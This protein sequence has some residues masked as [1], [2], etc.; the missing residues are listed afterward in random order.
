MRRRRRR[1]DRA[2]LAGAARRAA[3]TPRASLRPEGDQA[4]AIE[5]LAERVGGITDP[6]AAVV[7]ELDAARSPTATRRSP[8][9][10]TSSPGSASRARRLRELVRADGPAARPDF[11]VMV[12]VDDA[13]AA[14]RLRPDAD[15]AEPDAGRG[16]ELRG[17]RLLRSTGG[18]A[19][20][21]RRR[22]RARLRHRDGVQGR[23]RRR[24]T[25]SRWPRATST[26]TRLDALPDDP[27]ARSSSSRRRRSRRRSRQGD[28]DP[29]T[30]QVLEPLLGG[31]LSR[32]DRG[33][34]DRDRRHG[35]LRPRGDA[36]LRR[37][38]LATESS[39]LAEPAGRVL[40]RGRGARPRPE[41]RAR[42][43]TSSPAAAC[44]GRAR[45]S[46][47]C[48]RAT[49][50]D[51]GEDV[52]GWLGDAAA[53]VEGTAAPGFSAGLIAQTSDPEAPRRCSRCCEG[54]PSGTPACAPAARRR[55]P[56]YG[57]SLG[58]PGI[59]GGA[60]AGVIGDQLVA[61]VG[62]TVDQALEP[63]RDARRQPR[64]PGRGRGA[65]R[66]SARRRCSSTCRSSSRS[67]SS[68][69]RRRRR[70]RG[71]PPVPR[72]LLAR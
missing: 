8:T 6:G 49:G 31:P 54:S 63:E 11:A 62:A 50:L 26:P 41:P 45:S 48:M 55:A 24:A 34:P 30:A 14:S 65:R 53:F 12:E 52:F 21:V 47:R 27:L 28:V 1:L 20:G 18:F 7:A 17:H 43:S 69:V 58:I 32:A 70:L 35:Q 57:F 46:A 10:T 68:G 9:P 29:A 44:P 4:E 51:L 67:P 36:R 38:D 23:G 2:G 13:D 61:V 33:N 25:A 56:T 71:D 39:L 37:T 3:S 42:A 16:A 72:R 22:Q 60:E 59:G 19:V 64:V 15:R 40:V 66:R 5:S